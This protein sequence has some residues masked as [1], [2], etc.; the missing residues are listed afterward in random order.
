MTVPNMCELKICAL[1]A[2]INELVAYIAP[3]MGY[4]HM[5][6]VNNDISTYGLLG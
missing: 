3:L 5:I 6:L 4:E 2:K 1:T